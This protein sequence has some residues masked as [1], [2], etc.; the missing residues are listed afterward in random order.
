MKCNAVAEILPVAA[1]IDEVVAVMI[2]SLLVVVTVV[3][4]L[5]AALF[6]LFSFSTIFL[7]GKIFREKGPL[8]FVLLAPPFAERIM[9]NTHV[10]HREIPCY[11]Q[12]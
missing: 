2:V 6:L 1:V 3:M 4:V 5:A 11:L 12:R 8:S 10:L 7:E 9:I